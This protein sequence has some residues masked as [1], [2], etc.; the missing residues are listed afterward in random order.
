MGACTCVSSLLIKEG[1]R[2]LEYLWIGRTLLPEAR[3][4]DAAISTVPFQKPAVFSNPVE[5]AHCGYWPGLW[6]WG[7]HED[8]EAAARHDAFKS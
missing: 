4:V 2:Q 8:H 7:G 5:P 3:R 1:T 6:K